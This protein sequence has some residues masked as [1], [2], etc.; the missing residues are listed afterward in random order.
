M[1]HWPAASS[2]A[3][4]FHQAATDSRGKRRISIDQLEA[5]H[6]PRA[7]EQT[8]DSGIIAGRL[9]ADPTRYLP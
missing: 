3:K 1:S 7:S 2:I 4:E 9:V 6:G 5:L 8:L